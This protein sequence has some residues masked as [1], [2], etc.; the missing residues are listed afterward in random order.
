MS[1][2]MMNDKVILKNRPNPNVTEYLFELTKEEVIELHDGQFLVDVSYISIEPAMRG[3]ISEIGNYSKPVPING[4]M[5]S[6]GVGKIISSRNSSFRENEYVV[7][8]LGWQ[9]YSVVNE[10]Q[11]QTKISPNSIPLSANL[12][13][14]GLNGITAFAGLVDKCNPKKDETIVVTTAAGSVGSAVGQIAK[15][16]GCKTIGITGSDEKV[17][18]CRDEFGYDEV[19]NYKKTK[20]LYNE[21]KQLAPNGVDCFFDNVGGEQFDAVIENLNVN[22]RVLICGTTGMPSFPTPNGPR[23]NRLLLVKRAKIEGLLSF[24]YFDKY[25]EI[26]GQLLSWFQQGRLKN[27]EDISYGLHTAPQALVRVLNGQNLG[28]QLVKL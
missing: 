10:T 2:T 19:I 21:I 13:V 11:I 14:L 4:T 20:Y 18:I 6:L 16:F 24:D 28:K 3:W 7:G 17:A 5:R 27:R 26:S 25:Q 22:G 9:R 12:G 23:I 1:K 8:W 15:I